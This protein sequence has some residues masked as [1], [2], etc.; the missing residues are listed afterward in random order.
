MNK[1]NNMNEEQMEA[2]RNIVE[3][4]DDHAGYVYEGDEWEDSYSSIMEAV[5][6]ARTYLNSDQNEQ[7]DT[8]LPT[9]N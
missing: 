8:T 3:F 7:E 5:D 6:I 2:L 4:A 9:Q 1:H